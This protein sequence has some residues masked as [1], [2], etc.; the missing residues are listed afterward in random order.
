MEGTAADTGGPTRDFRLGQAAQSG[1]MQLLEAVLLEDPAAVIKSMASNRGKMNLVHK[2]AARGHADM[3]RRLLEVGGHH[4]TE[5]PNGDRAIHLAARA[6]KPA[7]LKALLV[8]GVDVTAK[9]KAGHTALYEAIRGRQAQCFALLVQNGA[10][11]QS[12]IDEGIVS[13]GTI[14][15]L[16]DAARGMTADQQTKPSTLDHLS[17]GGAAK[18]VERRR[19]VLRRE[20]EFRVK[21]LELTQHFHASP[22]PQFESRSSSRTDPYEVCAAI[23]AESKSA[24]FQLRKSLEVR[25]QS[26]S[27]IIE[28]AAAQKHYRAINAAKEKAKREAAADGVAGVSDTP[29]MP[30]AQATLDSGRLVA[31]INMR[32][33]Y[34][35]RPTKRSREKAV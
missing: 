14:A 16:R 13:E 15:Q 24:S 25:C 12:Y 27:N 34:R 22:K 31:T 11:Y 26:Q 6:G 28:Q 21:E 32:V 4:D 29:T 7:A 8:R 20:Q 17:V 2:A 9:N 19:E 30:F 18:E 10:D 3:V 23:I 33:P 1:D 35:V 5:L